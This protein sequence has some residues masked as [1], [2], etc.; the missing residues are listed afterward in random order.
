MP[1]LYDQTMQQLYGAPQQAT[2]AQPQQPARSLIQPLTPQDESS[3][4]ERMGGGALQGLGWVGGSLS[5]A[6][7]G[8]AIRGLL[9]GKP[10]ELL[11][12]IPFSDTLGITDA[13]DEVTGAE[14]LGNK[15]ASLLSP[16]GIGGIGVDILTDP[17]TYLSLGGS[18]VTKLGQLAKAK[19][20]LPKTGALRAAGLAAGTAEA[21]TLARAA[22]GTLGHM[23]PVAP[24]QLADVAGK[25]LGG[26]LGVGLPFSGNAATFDLTGAGN[27]LRS[28]LGALPGAG[29]VSNLAGKV[30]EA[31]DPLL[32]GGR[33][34]FDA[35]V[36]GQTGAYEQALMAEH[37]SPQLQALKVRTKQDVRP[38][39]EQAHN[40]NLLDPAGGRVLGDVLEGAVPAGQDTAGIYAGQRDLMNRLNQE[41][42]DSLLPRQDLTPQ[43][44]LHGPGKGNQLEYANRQL[45][46]EEFTGS[47]GRTKAFLP[48]E[49]K[50]R[51]SAT[52][53]L[54]RSSLEDLAKQDMTGMNQLQMEGVIRQQYMG[55]SANPHQD[56]ATLRQ[57]VT[58]APTPQ[59][60]QAAEA[61]IA[62][63]QTRMAQAAD[64]AKYKFE[65]KVPIYNHPL[66]DMTTKVF[67]DREKALKADVF[68]RGIAGLA[69]TQAEAGPGGVPF[70]DVLQRGGLAPEPGRLMAKTDAALASMGKNPMNLADMYLRPEEVE[71]LMKWMEGTRSPNGLAPFINLWDGITNTTKAWQTALWPANW[72]RNFMTDQFM[73]WI[74]DG[75]VGGSYLKSL[76]DAKSL[77][78]GGVLPDANK[79]IPMLAHLSPQDASMELQRMIV[80][81]GVTG[82]G[83][84]LRDTVGLTGDGTRLQDL[85]PGVQRPGLV[86]N[87]GKVFGA[88][89]WNPLGVAG[90]GGRT[91]DTNKLIKAG[92]QTNEG[93]SDI[94]RIQ[95]F[96]GKL[97]QGYTPEQALQITNKAHYDFGNLTGFEKEFAKRV[98]PFYGWA[99]Q[100]VPSVLQE[101]AEKP[102]GKLGTAVKVAGSARGADPGFL[103][104]QIAD[105][106]A[107]PLGQEDATGTKRFLSHS[108]LP[109][110]DL[111]QLGSAK[112]A[113][114]MLNPLIK[115]PLELAT[116]K[117][118]FTG[119]DLVDLHSD[120]GSTLMD[121]V[122]ANGPTGRIASTAR[123]LMDERKDL[124]SK[125]FNLLTGLHL[126]DVDMNKAKDIAVRDQIMESLRGSPNV[127][128]YTNLF[129]RPEQVANLSPQE[130]LLLRLKATR[131]AAARQAV[132][133]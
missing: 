27:A 86:E 9:G 119:R 28:G 70:R 19:G 33:A 59:V 94:T 91:E 130:L 126:T 35:N 13:A 39:I 14:L 69:V 20:I 22:A 31:A 67:K 99:R 46:K 92:R 77:Y 11:S 106:L 60:A 101:I 29:A 50:A 117:Q 115:A 103:P 74:H 121:Q 65:G 54:P 56:L 88:G 109:F 45:A 18:A 78:H 95:T 41:R 116:G 38:L 104:P 133:R 102:G 66:E 87:Y 52:S 48:A 80:D 23:G 129:V 62:E 84:L 7:G 16:E 97:S 89:E 30:R 37:Y 44:I 81:H 43:T 118:F 112:G 93:L 2:P 4:L 47:G 26:H 21:D 32:R 76:T 131:D 113:L 90:V 108:G 53:G 8:R 127:G 5:K 72:S 83:R 63:I 51:Q 15:D 25:S 82:Q 111:A 49:D 98:I 75:S 71:P 3:V 55:L 1:S 64:L 58:Q 36:Q 120:T 123:T 124:P 34:L 68:H 96:I 79:T 24:N 114:G 105:V 57:T 110:E 10:H 107:L 40:A 128:Q 125:A 73:N 61:Q 12:A 85:I 17:S 6:F 100:N 132:R 122:L 42:V